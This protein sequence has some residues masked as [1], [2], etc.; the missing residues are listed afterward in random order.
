MP[1]ARAWIRGLATFAGLT[2][3]LAGCLKLDMAIT[4]SPEDTVDGEMVF[5]VNKELLELTGQNLD[6]LLGDTSLPEDVEGATTEPYEDERFVGTRVTFE[7]VALAD[8]QESSDPDALTIERVGD[9]FEVGGVM[10][11]ATQDAEIEGNPFEAQIKE[12]FD[13]AELRIAITFPGE[14]LETNGRVDGTTVTWEPVFG[15]R[16]EIM[17][18]ASASSEGGEGSG[19]G[20]EDGTEAAGGSSE[21]SSSGNTLLYVIL[22][23]IAIAVVVGIFVMMRRR[24]AVSTPAGSPFPSDQD[25]VTA[26]VSPASAPEPPAVPPDAPGVPPA[27]APPVDPP[28]SPEEGGTP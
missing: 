17:A 16:T 8:M 7:G 12:A 25:A 24:G 19:E 15:E 3:L 10:D 4:L 6:D 26:P 13:T 2:L 22:G 5:A 20:T 14:V 18:V 9:T 11:L 21:G 28:R 23:L 27:P 1:T